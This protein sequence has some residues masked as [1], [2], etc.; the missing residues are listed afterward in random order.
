[1]QPLYGF[2]RAGEQPH[3]DGFPIE[4]IQ[5]NARDFLIAVRIVIHADKRIKIPHGHR[6]VVSVIFQRDARHADPVKDIIVQIHG[7]LRIVEQRSVKIPNDVFHICI[8]PSRC[9]CVNQ[10]AREYPPA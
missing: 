9:A 10:T 1:M 4:L 3:A 2:Q 8:I 7:E 6:H 5:P